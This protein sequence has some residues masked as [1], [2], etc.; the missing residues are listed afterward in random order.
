MEMVFAIYNAGL[1]REEVFT[2]HIY[3]HKVR[4][5]ILVS[6]EGWVSFA[7]RDTLNLKEEGGREPFL[8]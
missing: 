2:T 5:L 6:R 3:T 4:M 8:C 1:T 7:T